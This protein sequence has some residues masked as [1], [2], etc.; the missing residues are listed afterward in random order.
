MDTEIKKIEEGKTK[1]R[2]QGDYIFSGEFI[3]A[4]LFRRL[5]R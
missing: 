3:I 5:T 1:K 2:Q 4:S